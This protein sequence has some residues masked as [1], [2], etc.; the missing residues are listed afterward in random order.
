ME[1]KYPE[2]R[3]ESVFREGR[4]SY[5]SLKK[6]IDRLKSKYSN[7]YLNEKLDVIKYEAETLL[8]NLEKVYL[9]LFPISELGMPEELEEK[10][11]HSRLTPF[12][13]I[14]DI[15]DRLPGEYLC[16]GFD[17][18]EVKLLEN[19]LEKYNL[20]LRKFPFIRNSPFIKKNQQPP[21]TRNKSSKM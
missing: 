15:V 6:I 19:T 18:S 11:Y 20:R 3:V 14:F 4:R 12:G 13:T 10:L 16:E 8:I 21:S 2:K 17:M 5:K 9:K 7:N 1:L